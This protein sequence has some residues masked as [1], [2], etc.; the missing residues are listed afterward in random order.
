MDS[1]IVIDA[2]IRVPDVGTFRYIGKAR[3]S[4]A[5]NIRS[6]LRLATLDD[7]RRRRPYDE[8]N[9]IRMYG[10]DDHGRRAD[11]FGMLDFCTI[12]ATMVS[13]IGSCSDRC[14]HYLSS[15]ND[16]RSVE[17]CAAFDEYAGV[18]VMHWSVRD[19]G[20]DVPDSE[21]QFLSNSDS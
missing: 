6:A 17:V 14:R 12:E 13:V 20:G 19:A 8:G 3:K 21:R 4:Q 9:G 15:H 18:H 10:D 7:I 16:D 5:D 1:T 11:T 2:M